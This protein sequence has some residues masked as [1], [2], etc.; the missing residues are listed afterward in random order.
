MHYL[1]RSF[2]SGLAAILALLVFAAS[3][4]L[5]AP[6]LAGS[7]SFT[8]IWLNEVELP[9]IATLESSGYSPTLNANLDFTL[10]V[11]HILGPGGHYRLTGEIFTDGYYYPLYDPDGITSGSASTLNTISLPSASKTYTVNLQLLDTDTSV[12]LRSVRFDIH[13]ITK[14]STAPQLVGKDCDP[15]GSEYN[16]SI[17]RNIEVAFSED[18][19]PGSVNS[20]SIYLTKDGS[21]TKISAALSV[22]GGDTVILDP[23][24]DLAY[25]TTYKV[26]VAAGGIKD[27]AGNA[28]AAA[29]YT[30]TTQGNPSTAAAV[31][32]RNPG[33]GAKNVDV[34]SDIEMIF[35]KE[36][37][38]AASDF[39]TAGVALKKG[40]AVVAASVVPVNVNG[41]CEITLTPLAA[42]D[43]SS[44]YTV[45][46]GSNRLKDVNGRS[47]GATSWSFTTEAGSLPVIVDREPDA[48]DS[49]VLF[50]QPIIIDF[51]KPL[52][53]STVTS[54]TVY[55]RKSGSSTKISATL[56]F[57]NS[58]KTV[59]LTPKAELQ[60]STTYYVYITNNVKDTSGNR[61]T[62][63]NWYFTTSPDYVRVQDKY[64]AEDATNVPVDTRITFKF[65]D[66]MD[67]DTIDSGSVFLRRDGYS[68]K[69]SATVEYNESTRVVTLT[70]KS[71]LRYNESY[72][73]YVTDEVEDEHGDEIEAVEWSFTTM[74]DDYPHI[75]KRTPAP[76]SS[77][78]PVDG[79]IEMTFS[80]AMKS[81]TINTT[82][83]CLRKAGS[84][85]KISATVDYDSG[86]R[87]ATLKPKSALAYDTEYTVYVT[88]GVQD[89]YGTAVYASNWT[90]RT[91]PE[92]AKISSLSP[93]DG[94]TKVPVEK[95]ITFKF[96]RAMKSSTIDDDN[97][98]LKEA[99]SS[100]KV[101]ADVDYSSSTRT[102]T[103]D[104]DN[105]LKYGTKYYL[106][107][108]DDV[109]DADG[110]AVEAATYSFTT[111][112]ETARKGTATRPLVRCNGK[113]IDFTDVHPYITAGRT[114]I[115]Y[116]ALAEAMG[117]YVEYDASN[118]A[119][120]KITA[121]LGGNTI[122]LYI[123][124]K[125]A[126]RNGVRVTSDT[127]PEILNSRTMI[128]FRF[129]A[130]ALG[131]Y[132]DYDYDNYIVIV[133]QNG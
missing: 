1:K 91:A 54:S 88:T 98:Y 12:A 103:V 52:N 110:Y 130:E 132:V 29:S 133:E 113:Y 32:S 93:A 122:V 90:F 27:L 21:S 59:I 82:N 47:V 58:N 124:D 128:P 18:I 39:T 3:V 121:T 53:T 60:S 55:L 69:I 125:A 8:G 50:D 94:A 127:A 68:S 129:C 81:S 56:S 43:A 74:D 85:T 114:M 5:P 65:S 10:R 30:F 106:Y 87:M 20:S 25:S 112:A 115:P 9:S 15:A 66:D 38:L 83:I 96:S 131:A 44:T 73:V 41:R 101:A 86:D 42:L 36:L 97:I 72:T 104:P 126:Y 84:S 45:S 23:A 102:V 99:G 76:G 26:W 13:G 40:T 11:E 33:S 64:P 75:I 71:N 34:D 119:R 31:V 63:E 80:T 61:V 108:T 118:P 19:L 67:E 35:D 109:E 78:F 120:Q 7:G 117:A 107:I 14:D 62:A 79:T 37:D 95:E 89:K 92:K 116:R 111:A 22:A 77:G 24:S 70:P 49:G 48:K 6:V 51:N 17:N 57:S 16:V 105:N 46:I 123:G 4:S 2:R 100:A 28:A